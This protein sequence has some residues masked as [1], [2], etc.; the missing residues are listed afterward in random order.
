[1][2]VNFQNLAATAGWPS[3]YHAIGLNGSAS[4]SGFSSLMHAVMREAAGV[5]RDL[6]EKG[7][8]VNERGP[9]GLTAIHRAVFFCA[10]AEATEDAASKRLQ[11]RVRLRILAILLGTGADTEVTCDA[12]ETAL[13]YAAALGHVAAVKMLIEAHA[14]IEKGSLWSTERGTMGFTALHRAAAADR[15]GTLRVLLEAHANIEAGSNWGSPLVVAAMMS[16]FEAVKVLL[17]AGANVHSGNDQGVTALHWAGLEGNFEIAEVLLEAGA[18][19]D[20]LTY[21]GDTPF[22]LTTGDDDDEVN[23]PLLLKPD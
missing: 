4:P 15:P 12:G 21:L 20:A 22:D 16:N 7:A 5:A 13:H 6:L 10:D 2:G 9:G 18:K 19:K 17:E 23:L 14:N 3:L 11:S 1:M 8:E